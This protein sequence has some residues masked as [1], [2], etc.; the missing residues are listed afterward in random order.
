[1]VGAKSCQKIAV[2][3]LEEEKCIG[4]L[5]DVDPSIKGIGVMYGS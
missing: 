4:F 3:S 5:E 2:L 1:L